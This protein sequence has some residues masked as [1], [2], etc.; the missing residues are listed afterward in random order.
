MLSLACVYIL[1]ACAGT[2][3]PQATQA[4]VDTATLQATPVGLP[5]STEEPKVS[6]IDL[7][8]NIEYPIDITSTGKAKLVNGVFEEPAAPGSATKTQVQLTKELA[9]GD[10]NGDGFE[11]ALVLLVA[12]PGGSGTFTYLALVL[13]DNGNPKPIASVLL[14]DRIIVKSL[15]I[16]DGQVV[17]KLLTRKPDEPMSAKPTVDVTRIFNLEGDRLHEVK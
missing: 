10:I 4:I 5:T 9:T 16:Q 1:S 15:A 7:L 2:S 8:P 17:V 3:T 6:I 12:D 13:N 11:D 14:G